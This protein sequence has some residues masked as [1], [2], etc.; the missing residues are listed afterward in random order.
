[1]KNI[2]KLKNIIVLQAVIVIYTISSVMAKIA[3]SSDSTQGFILFFAFDILFLGI[4][5]ILWQQMI[6]RFEL[7]IAYTNRAVALL[8]S[9][10]WAVIIFKESITTKQIIGVLFVIIGTV[11]VNTKKEEKERV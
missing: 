9:A 11:I 8:W 10:V 1:M 3:S 2:K 4:Y 5:A 7:S 6:K